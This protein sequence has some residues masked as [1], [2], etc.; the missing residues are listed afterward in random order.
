M[1]VPIAVRW[2]VYDHYGNMIYL[3]H[4]RWEHIVDPIN[5]P[6]FIGHEEKLKIAI[7]LGIRKQDPLNPQK[8]RYT[9][10]FDDLPMDNTHVVVIVLYR[11]R[12]EAGRLAPNN[13]VVTAYQIEMD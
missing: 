12:D 13:Y 4:E 8:Y 2:V 10:T 1:D 7:Q 3:T 6:E 5:H 9:K 11:Y